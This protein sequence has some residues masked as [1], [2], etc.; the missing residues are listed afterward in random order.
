[1]KKNTP[2]NQ[3]AFTIIETLVAIFILSL[4]ITGPLFYVSNT[5]HL[6]RIAKYEMTAYFLATETLEEIKYKRDFDLGYVDLANFDANTWIFDLEN[7]Q[8]NV[9]LAGSFDSDPNVALDFRAC[10]TISTTPCGYLKYTPQLG[11][12]Y[13]STSP[14]SVFYRYA[15]IETPTSQSE[16][17][18]EVVVGWNDGLISGELEIFEYIYDFNG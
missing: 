13:N 7:L 18:V 14:S 10:D 15:T 12:H 17:K 2:K 11:F 4:S 5:F 6:A 9:S 8:N 1:M 3:K 16:R